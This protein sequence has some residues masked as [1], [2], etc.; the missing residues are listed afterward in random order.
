[1]H[2]PEES[3]NRTLADRRRQPT[4]L[5]SKY[6]CLGGQRCDIRRKEDKARYFFVDVYSPGLF[7][8]LLFLLMLTV[9]DS[10]FTLIL[11]KEHVAVEANPIMRFY[12]KSSSTSFVAMKFLI[13]SLSILIFCLCKNCRITKIAITV[14]IMVYLTVTLYEVNILFYFSPRF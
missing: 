4:P 6:T 8:A 11:M 10:Y 14:A 5:I 9:A 7:M 13:S 3:G 12:L 2:E 1:M